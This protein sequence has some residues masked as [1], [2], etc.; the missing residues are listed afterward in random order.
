MYKENGKEIEVLF[1][2]PDCN[3]GELG[4]KS[5]LMHIKKGDTI[6]RAY[7]CPNCGEADMEIFEGTDIRISDHRFKS[8]FSE[9]E[10]LTSQS[11]R[12]VEE[13]I[14]KGDNK[15]LI[16]TALERL[17]EDGYDEFEDDFSVYCF[18]PKQH[19]LE[20]NG[21]DIVDFKASDPTVDARICSKCLVKVICKVKGEKND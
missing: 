18:T 3:Y 9:D 15:K 17:K 19:L 12:S 14:E 7:T 13:I 2:C 11:S 16:E 8:K 6:D 1:F 21:N 4:N 5:D 20:E 10:L